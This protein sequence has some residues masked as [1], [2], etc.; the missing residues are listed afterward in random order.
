MAG[1]SN[2]AAVTTAIA[3]GQ[4]YHYEFAKT[5]A[6]GQ[7]RLGLPYSLWQATGTPAAGSNPATGGVVYDNTNNTGAIAFQPT[8]TKNKYLMRFGGCADNAGTLMLFDRLVS[9]G[10]VSLTTAT[11]VTVSAQSLPRYTSGVDVFCWLEL[12]TA[13]SSS[14][15]TAVAL[16]YTNSGGTSG[17]TGSTVTIGTTQGI[18]TMYGL[19]VQAGDLG[20]QSIQSLTVSVANTTAV[21]SLSLMRHIATLPIVADIWNERDF[22]LELAAMPQIFDGA[23]LMLVWGNGSGAVT[24]RVTGSLDIVYA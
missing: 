19:S 20:I 8:S 7:T 15:A 12:T 6:N 11:T 1:F 23:S 2:Y 3:A 24:P 18:N 14:G 9:Y 17:R 4:R 22:V 21:A 13:A 10:N 16:N 5:A